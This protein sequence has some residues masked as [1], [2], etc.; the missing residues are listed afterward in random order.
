MVCSCTSL[1]KVSRHIKY[2]TTQRTPIIWP[3]VLLVPCTIVPSPSS[4]LFIKNFSQNSLV[5]LDVAPDSDQDSPLLDCNGQP[6]P[7][8]CSLCGTLDSLSTQSLTA[9]CNAVQSNTAILTCDGSFF[10]KRQAATP[11]VVVNAVKSVV[12]SLLSSLIIGLAQKVNYK[13]SL[14]PL[15]MIANLPYIPS[16]L[17]GKIEFWNTLEIITT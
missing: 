2:S 11:K 12:F 1:Y 3:I 9:I 15:S 13:G 14:S 6:H 16:S 7:F 17:N 8:F 5:L 4:P 10:D